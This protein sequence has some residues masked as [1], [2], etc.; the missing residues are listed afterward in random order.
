MRAQ[1]APHP[2]G[3]IETLSQVASES[4]E[5]NFFELLKA[6]ILAGSLG[7]DP[8]AVTGGN[9]IEDPRNVVGV[10]GA[11]FDSYSSNSDFQ[12]IQI[13]VNTI[14]LGAC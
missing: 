2:F 4:R 7:R 10:T 6:G 5:P 9:F 12:I 13:G 14:D 8:G 1:T 3:S 11:D